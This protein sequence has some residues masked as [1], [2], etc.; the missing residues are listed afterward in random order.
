[1]DTMTVLWGMRVKADVSPRVLI[2]VF[3]AIKQLASNQHLSMSSIARVI[4]SHQYMSPF[5]RYATN[6]RI[7]PDTAAAFHCTLY[8]PSNDG[9]IC[10]I[11]KRIVPCPVKLTMT[12]FW[13]NYWIIGDLY[14]NN[15]ADL[16]K[17]CCLHITNERMSDM[18]NLMHVNCPCLHNFI[19]QK[20]TQNWYIRSPT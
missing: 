9:I 13:I 6:D 3:P 11:L 1:M 18:T 5:L 15:R 16:I 19:Y 12:I 20:C 8:H 4:N 17:I 14:I 2:F 7:V 10:R